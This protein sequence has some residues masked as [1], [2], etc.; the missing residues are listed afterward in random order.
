MDNENLIVH[1]AQGLK[2]GSL[3]RSFSEKQLPGNVAEQANFMPTHLSKQTGITPTSG[4][5][6]QE[7]P[8]NSAVKKTTKNQQSEGSGNEAS[9]MDNRI[10]A[11]LELERRVESLTLRID[12][13]L[14]EL[15][16]K[17]S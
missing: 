11:L 10:S 9:V 13:L 4:I 17:T 14:D 6:H 2:R 15:D 8:Y 12:T 1:N 16:V 5:I 7:R 3:T